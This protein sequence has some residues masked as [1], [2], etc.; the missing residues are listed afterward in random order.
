MTMA[1]NATVPPEHAAA[2][3][4]TDVPSSPNPPQRPESTNSGAATTLVAPPEGF[5]PLPAASAP[6]ALPT[7]GNPRPESRPASTSLASPSAATPGHVHFPLALDTGGA[8][9]PSRF[10]TRSDTA[11]TNAFSPMR[12]RPTRVGTFKAVE[13]FEEYQARPG[14][15]RESFCPS[16]CLSGGSLLWNA[17]SRN[18]TL[19]NRL[20][21]R[22]ARCRPEQIRRRAC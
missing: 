4:P 21:W 17:E 16:S 19:T 15:R 7:L 22:R 6:S 5:M 14:W 18:M 12:R 3:P 1:D 20:S 13:D 11:L 8:F 9:G 10:L 2:P